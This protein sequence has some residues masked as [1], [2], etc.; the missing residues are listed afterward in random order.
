M[1]VV[2]KRNTWNS[3]S[4][5]SP[6]FKLR[7]LFFPNFD[8]NVAELAS[9]LAN[10][11]ARFKFSFYVSVWFLKSAEWKTEARNNTKTQHTR[12]DSRQN[13]KKT[14]HQRYKTAELMLKASYIDFWHR[15]STWQKEKAPCHVWK[16]N[17]RLRGSHMRVISSVGRF[18]S[19][20]IDLKKQKKK[21]IL[22]FFV[23]ISVRKCPLCPRRSAEENI[24]FVFFL[25][26]FPPDIHSVCPYIRKNPY[27][28]KLAFFSFLLFFF[29]A[30][31]AFCC[32]PLVVLAFE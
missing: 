11:V 15:A 28:S 9:V 21:K 7:I 10:T 19:A 8:S 32:P 13:V 5:Q 31:L 4:Q 26:F 27:S 12:P 20:E 6:N 3:N 17:N 16:G 2:K 18:S 24:A 23:F 29:F 1:C 22:P 30:P 25:F 14:Q